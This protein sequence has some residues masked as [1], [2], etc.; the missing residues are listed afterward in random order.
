MDV[1]IA[2]EDLLRARDEQ[3]VGGTGDVLRA[4][5]NDG[6][7]SRLLRHDTRIL[8]A[9]EPAKTHETKPAHQDEDENDDD[10]CDDASQVRTLRMPHG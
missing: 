3:V 10:R 4:C 1:Q 5:G 9:P 8:V 6:G 2:K 7:R